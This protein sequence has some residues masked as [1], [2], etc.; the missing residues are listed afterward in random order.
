M[1]QQILDSDLTTCRHHIESDVVTVAALTRGL[2]AGSRHSDFHVLELR[3]ELRHGIGQSELSIFKQ[4]Q[5]GHASYGFRH[6]SEAEDRVL[7]HRSLGF[8]VHQ[9]LRLEVCNLAPASQERI[10]AR[11]VMGV[12]M[13]WERLTNATEPVAGKTDILRLCC[14][15]GSRM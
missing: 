1:C 5:Y 14:W 11:D 13:T 12:D 4:Q 6:R 15:N 2:H 3:N 9:T 7:P 10:G 8:D